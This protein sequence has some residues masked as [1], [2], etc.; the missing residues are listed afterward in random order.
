MDLNNKNIILTGASSGIGLEMLKKM[1]TSGCKIVAVARTI[2]KIAVEY[3]NVTKYP[4]D[5]SHPEN[6]DALFEF[7]T[8]KMGSIDIYIANAGFAY[9]GEITGPSWKEIDKIYRTN[10]FSSIYAA[11]KMKKIH[12]DQPFQ[13]AI[14]ASAMSF[15]S[16][17]GYALYSSTKAALRGFATGYRSEL[18]KGQKLQ[19]IYPI[20]TRTDFFKQAGSQTPIPWPTQSAE[21]VATAIIN[22]LKKEKTSIFPSKLFQSLLILNGYLP[23]IF[24][25]IILFEN[26][27]FRRWLTRGA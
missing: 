20:G 7:A 3:N 26:F 13:M 1:A 11:E 5:I 22:G 23:F 12:G 21:K 24:K 18:L 9:Y 27:K 17:P 4:C 19:M 16:Y 25:S 10:V 8:E 2:D 14:T 15:L 6:L